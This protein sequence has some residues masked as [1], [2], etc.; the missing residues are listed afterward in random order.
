EGDDVSG[1]L[2]V[3]SP[4]TDPDGQTDLLHVL[5]EDALGEIVV[6]EGQVFFAKVQRRNNATGWPFRVVIGIYSDSG[7]T[8]RLGQFV[9]DVAPDTD[10]I[11]NYTLGPPPTTDD[12]GAP[13]LTDL[14]V[15]Y[16][17]KGVGAE[18]EIVYVWRCEVANRR[19]DV[20]A[21]MKSALEVATTANGYNNDYTYSH[22][23]LF[24]WDTARAGSF[25]LIA[26]RPGNASYE[27][28]TAGARRATMRFEIVG[29]YKR[30]RADSTDE[31]SRIIKDI[32]RA[33]AN[34]TYGDGTT[35]THLSN[36]GVEMISFVSA[37][38]DPYVQDDYERGRIAVEVDLVFKESKSEITS[39]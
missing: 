37:Q 16:A 23:K 8:D 12:A 21:A 9:R 6:Y 7:L 4:I 19:L 33:L 28:L 11:G 1:P 35:P 22:R 26:W 34:A 31:S 20:V 38:T 3:L 10:G 24:E 14:S 30:T 25:P 29:F 13:D 39:A 18:G 36:A 2:V 5:G 15:Q 27:M 32:E 17:I